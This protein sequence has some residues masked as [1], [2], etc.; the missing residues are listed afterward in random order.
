MSE[1]KSTLTWMRESAD[2]SYDTYNREHSWS[3]DGGEVIKASAS[4]AYKGNPSCVDPEETLV[5]AVSSCQ[6]LTFLA[7]A[8]KKRF[9][10]DSYTDEAVGIL[11]KDAD[12][13]LAITRISLNPR[14]GFSG[15]KKPSQEKL[16]QLCEAAHEHCFIASSIKSEVQ[17]KPEKL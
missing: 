6:M 15:E 16:H 4:P 7:L 1:H 8:A 11:E 17:I 14:I 9:I 5:A 10:V 2:F 12:G 3:F 13:K